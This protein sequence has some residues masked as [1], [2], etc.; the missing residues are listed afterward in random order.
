MLMA[1]FDTLPRHARRA[2]LFVTPL[3]AWSACAPPA[4]GESALPQGSIAAQPGAR[5]CHAL[6]PASSSQVQA[7]LIGARRHAS[8]VWRDTPPFN[9]DGS[10]N[11]YVEIP[12]GERRKWELDIGANQLRLDRMLDVSVGGYPVNYGFVPQTASCDGDPFDVLVLGAP[13]ASGTL[14]AGTVVGVMYMDDEKGPD[15]KVIIAPRPEANQE[16]STL[17]AELEAQLWRWF[18]AYKAADADRG[19]WSAVRGFGSADE[20]RRLVELTHGFYRKERD[21]QTER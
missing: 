15:G 21:R 9:A 20:G 13:I 7:A 12:A 1:T 2:L 14:L 5:L 6:P 10:L 11:G 4:G 18:D 8:H 16:P 19:R 3:A 17:T